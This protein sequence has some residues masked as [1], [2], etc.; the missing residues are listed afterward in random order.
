MEHWGDGEMKYWS[1]GVM[2]Y[3]G[4]KLRGKRLEAAESIIA[5]RLTPMITRRYLPMVP[6]ASLLNFSN[7]PFPHHSGDSGPEGHYKEQI[8]DESE[9]LPLLFAIA[10]YSLFG[11]CEDNLHPER[12]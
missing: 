5:G 4:G 7:T 9:A 8:R 10:Y 11:S 1:G 3:W 12:S 6:V 2:S